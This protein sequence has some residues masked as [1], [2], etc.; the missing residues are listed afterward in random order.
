M[1]LVLL[2]VLALGLEGV[3]ANLLIILLQGG[4]VLP[5]LRELSLLHA[6]SDVPEQEKDLK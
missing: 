1:F 2:S 5:G 4:H 3:H 6:L